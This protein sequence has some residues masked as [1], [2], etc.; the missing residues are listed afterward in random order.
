MNYHKH[1]NSELNQFDWLYPKYHYIKTLFSYCKQ[2]RI[3]NNLYLNELFIKIILLYL[4]Y[5]LL[6]N[7]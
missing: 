3:I 6:K 2:L 1:S 7:L 5:S 4:P